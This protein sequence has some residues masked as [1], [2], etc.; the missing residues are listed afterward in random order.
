MQ[1]FLICALGRVLL[2][3]RQL[4][5]RN[6]VAILL[7]LGS[8]ALHASEGVTNG[9]IQLV[10]IADVSGSRRAL[11]NELNTG[12]QAYFSHVNRNGGVHGR[13]ITLRSV[14]DGY[15][16]PRTVRAVQDLVRDDDAFAVVSTVGTANTEAV[17]DLLNDKS[18]PLIAP[19]SGATSVREP[20]RRY[21][22]NVRA[23]YEREVEAMVEHVHTIGNRR[24]AIF[25]DDD[26]FGRDVL[27][28]AEKALAQYKLKPVAVGKVD[29][30]SVDVS[31]AVRAI[32]QEDPQVVICG[33]FGKSLVKFVE[34]LKKERAR[35]QLY[36]LSFFTVGAAMKELGPDAVG[37][38][39]TQVMP[40][41]KEQ[42]SALQREFRGI[43]AE[44]GTENPSGYVAFEGFVTA[45]VVVEALRRVGPA[46]T[47]EKFVQ[48]LETLRN[49]D[50]GGPR[51][52]YTPMNHLG[53]NRV[54]ITL[55]GRNGR[56]VK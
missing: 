55:I 28:G 11:T 19:L 23:G 51:L 9:A 13:K 22:F 38:S 20:M 54:E 12:M 50:L 44:S 37:V 3:A 7:L 6:L 49:F 30:G 48:A 40:S 41:P 14:D 42:A 43:M 16:V 52:T 8:A 21:V 24:V 31:A 26:A 25:Y 2:V 27:R 47:R 36:A 32:A 10:Q 35:P 53:L 56:I 39:V 17:I 45:K 34:A 15:E 4:R 1:T 46:L 33:S 5:S 29:R 18:I